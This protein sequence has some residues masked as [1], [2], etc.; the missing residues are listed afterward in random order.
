MM[1]R[2]ELERR[3]FVLR[4]VVT[5]QRRVCVGSIWWWRRKKHIDRYNLIV[6]TIDTLINAVRQAG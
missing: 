1:T 3:L 2:A 4:N 6:T 5:E